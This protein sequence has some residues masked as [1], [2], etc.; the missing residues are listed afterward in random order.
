MPLPHETG[1]RDTLFLTAMP[2]VSEV[3]SWVC[4]RHGSS[5]EEREEFNSLVQVKLLDDNCALLRRFAQ[6]SSL[7]TYLTVV[8]Q[9]L[10]LDF[11]RHR[12][13]VWRP[14]AE[15]RRLGETAVRLEILT[16]RDGLHM[17][18]AVEVLCTNEGVTASR[19]DLWALA[20]RL[21]NRC[22]RREECLEAAADV[23]VSA[24]EVVEEPVLRAERARRL[25][26]L[27]SA[28]AGALA[29]L[30]GE[31]ALILRLRFVEGFTAPRI[32]SVLG[33]EA[34]PLYRRIEGLLSELREALDQ[35]GFGRADVSDLLDSFAGE[36]D[37]EVSIRSPS[38]QTE[39]KDTR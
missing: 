28:L 1:E 17:D 33:L 26:A 25:G 38:P 20:A 12:W 39:T 19:A 23:A 2:V 36:A 13:G 22:R 18:E 11:R 16:C 6:R 37:L 31:G 8:I 34:K 14:S 32:A 9:R 15:A 29:T 35:Q 27:R 10:F 5:R 3:V 21:P 4:R 24:A 30:D 7:K